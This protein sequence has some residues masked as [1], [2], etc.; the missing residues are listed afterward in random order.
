VCACACVCVCVCVYVCA[1]VCVWVCVWVCSRSPAAVATSC[2]R[3]V[4][5][6]VAYHSAAAAAIA[7]SCGRPAVYRRCIRVLPPEFS[8]PQQ[9]L[10]LRCACRVP[11]CA[12]NSSQR[13]W[14]TC[15]CAPTTAN[16]CCDTICRPSKPLGLTLA[17]ATWGRCPRSKPRGAWASRRAILGAAAPWLAGRGGES[18]SAGSVAAG[19]PKSAIRDIRETK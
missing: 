10:R 16:P 4:V 17:D 9:H 12:S 7:T 1:C 11:S 14:R 13:P 6:A 3:P 18:Q 5:Y 8:E 19:A 2:S 15:G